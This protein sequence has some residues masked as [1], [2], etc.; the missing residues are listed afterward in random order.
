MHL[1][2]PFYTFAFRFDVA[3]MRAEVEALPEEAWLH[4]VDGFKGNSHLPLI[5]TNGEMNNRVDAPMRPTEFFERCPYIKQVFA[6]FRTLHGRARLMRLEPRDGVPSHVDLKYYWLSRTRVH[7]PIVTDPGIRFH[8]GPA[9]VHMAAGEAWTFDNCRLHKVVNDTKTRRIHLT[10]DT[11]GSGAF[12]MM[13]HPH[14]MPAPEPEFVP[15]RPGIVPELAYEN[16]VTPPVLPPSEMEIALGR[17]TM[18]AADNPR[19]DREAVARLHAFVN[20]LVN[21]WRVK[22]YE[23]GPDAVDAFEAMQR[24]A[25][26]AVRT[27]PK[28]LTFAS[29]GSDVPGGLTA[30]FQAMVRK[31][32]ESAAA[33][34]MA[35]EPRFEKPVFIVSA[36][37]SGSTMLFETLAANGAFHTLGGEG[38]VHVEAIEALKP[39]NRGFDSNRLEAR[40]ATD[41][42]RAQLRA[43]YAA[44][45]RDA[46]GKR[47]ADEGTAARFLEKTPKN[48][49]R[50]PFLKAVFPDARFIFLHREPRANISAIMEA[51]RSGGFVTYANLPDWRGSPW[52]LLLI[53]GWRDLIGAEMAQIAMRQWRDTNEIILDDLAALPERDWISVRYEDVLADPHGTFARLCAF[54]E[55]PFDARLAAR[56]AGPL[57]ASRTTLTAPD[58]GKWRKNERAIEPLMPEAAA[59]VA[60]LAALEGARAERHAAQ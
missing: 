11:L 55:V 23:T 27:F 46:D 1:R 53:P 31:D 56:L 16:Y 52:S 35:A 49:L 38:H 2:Y 14:G 25:M 7:I 60:R 8:C 58:P 28:T 33:P 5:S 12:W 45:L 36:P 19:N 37:R 10:F 4:H 43:N 32:A 57:P 40:D 17:M 59:L 41:E 42:V 6:Q 18:D 47:W 30:V 20:A 3:R 13:A 21:E 54:A 29:N 44:D 48:A 34:R 51:W 39:K 9:S 22:W 26:E 24:Q 15:Y 50:I